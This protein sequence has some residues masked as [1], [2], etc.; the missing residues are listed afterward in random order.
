MC[1][2]WDL[3]F[4]D[5]ET[6]VFFKYKRFFIYGHGR[7]CVCCASRAVTLFHCSGEQTERELTSGVVARSRYWVP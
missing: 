6:H 3:H 4:P 1:A 7:V 5:P 2:P